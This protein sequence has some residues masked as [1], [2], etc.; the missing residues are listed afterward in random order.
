MAMRVQPETFSGLSPYVRYAA[1]PVRSTWRVGPRILRDYLL[2]LVESGRGRMVIDNREIPLRRGEWYWVPPG[3]EVV[4]EGFAPPRMLVPFVHF[5]V[6]YDKRYAH[7]PITEPGFLDR[8]H[9]SIQP[10]LFAGPP[11]F[12]EGK[13]VPKVFSEAK[14]QLY[15]IVH[16]YNRHPPFFRVETSALLLKLIANFANGAAFESSESAVVRK[17]E[18]LFEKNITHPYTLRE[19]GQITGYNPLYVGRLFESQKGL[20]P[21]QFQ[22][23]LRINRAKDMIRHSAMTFTAIAEECGFD[24]PATFSRAFRRCESISPTEYLEGPRRA[25]D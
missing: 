6:I 25:K 5:D 14:A 21:K 13:V 23:R 24:S 4:L 1:A 9:A 7:L 19:L 20:S 22:L 12:L 11:V 3:K 2:F 18:R 10:N 16:I 15:E 17:I 8:R